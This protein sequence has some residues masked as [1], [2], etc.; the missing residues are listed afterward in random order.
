MSR[1]S[2]EPAQ[3]SEADAYVSVRIPSG[4][5]L[6][7]LRARSLCLADLHAIDLDAREQLRALC[8]ESCKAQAASPVS[9]DAPIPGNEADLPAT[10]VRGVARPLAQT[11][12]GCAKQPEGPDSRE[13]IGSLS[14]P[15]SPFLLDEAPQPA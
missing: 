8:L 12:A 10:P 14:P 4:K 7:L 1:V 13:R 6:E 11:G 3:D 5:L 9:V 2:P 15:Q